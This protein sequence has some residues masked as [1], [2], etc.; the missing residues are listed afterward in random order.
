MRV[1]MTLWLTPGR[2]YSTPAAAAAP[3]K[4]DTPGVTSQGMPR[5]SSWSICSR[6]APYRQGSPVWR[7]TVFPPDRSVCS[8]TSSTCSRVIWALLYTGTPSRTK[9]SRAGFTRLPAYTTQSACFNS[10]AP[11]RVIRS[12]PPGPAPTK[13]TMGRTSCFAFNAQGILPSSLRFVGRDD[14]GAP[15]C[16]VSPCGAS[17]FSTWKR[18]QKTLGDAA[19]ANFV[20]HAGLPPAPPLRGL[21]LGPGRKFPAHKI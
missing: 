20:R 14:L 17:S 15:F 7:R 11:R 4:E 10:S 13:W 18:N 19:G 16:R 5:R 9:P 6:T 12:G 8:S 2:V 3:Q 1:M 21:P